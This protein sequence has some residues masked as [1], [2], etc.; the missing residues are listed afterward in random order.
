[1]V[2]FLV[3]S[4][5][6]LI[7]GLAHAD[8]VRVI[9]DTGNADLVAAVE[10]AVASD[11]DTD[12]VFKARRV[13][14]RS[15]ETA[16]AY[17]NSEGYF[18]PDISHAVEAGPPIRPLI[19]VEPG[20]RFTYGQLEISLGNSALS[21]DDKAILNAA[22]SLQPGQIVKPGDVVAQ[23]AGLLS[24]L[25]RLGYADAKVRDR[26][27]IGDRDAATLDITYRLTPGPRIRFGAVR[28]DE[29]VRTRRPYLERLNPLE[30]GALYTPGDLRD[31]NR[32]LGGTRLYRIATA[33]LDP[34]SAG[35]NDADD[36]VRDVIVTLE[37]RERYSL[38]AGASFSTG[39]GLGLTGG[40]VRRNAT[41]RGDIASVTAVVAEQQRAFRLDWRIPNAFAYDRGL[42]FSAELS[43]EETDA[44]DRDALTVA[45]A[46]E[47]KRSERFA[48]SFGAAGEFT[49]EEDAFGQR[50]AQ[51]L[52]VSAAARLD[53]SDDV[54][55]PRNGWRL[56]G[57]VE[58]AIAIGDSETQ[59]FTATAQASAYRPVV[60][61]RLI[62]AVRARGGVVV[63]AD[64]EVLPVSRRFFAGGG[65]SARGFEYQSIGP[66]REDG[67]P[68]GGRGL[69]EFSAELRWQTKGAL[70][71]VAFVD[72]A[73]VSSD[74]D[75]EIAEPR[76]GVGVGVR[77]KTTVGPIR[78]DIATPLDRRDGEDP[79]HIYV[80]I[81]QAF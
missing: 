38:T 51:I 6:T 46:Y 47:V 24:T 2:R 21:D 74:A 65:G 15:A 25:R 63:G 66:E 43:N 19:R 57:R 55:D 37:E 4:C 12:T 58:P 76:Y 45:G 3:L 50:D 60:S 42:D 18:D 61:E 62:A 10:Q 29:G 73:S 1:M 41:R 22:L 11:A 69:V 30:E 34:D 39:E 5:V 16:R 36:E 13:A 72:A 78:F 81:G 8:P 28:F 80:S 26:R 35:A 27:V 40:L 56:D 17:L 33:R 7:A 49:T 67:T 53:R 23:E 14:R 31:F 54:L 9:S 44:F 48:Y 64:V 75:L 52:S 71:Y 68:E 59:F 77:Y 79:L 20:P 32:R 70:G